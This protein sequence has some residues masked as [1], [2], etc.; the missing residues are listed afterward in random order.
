MKFSAV[1]IRNQQFSVSFRGY[2]KDEVKLFLEKLADEYEKLDNELESLKKENEKNIAELTGYRNTEKNLQ[3]T[4]LKAR[5]TSVKAIEAAKKQA[6]AIVR[7]AEIKSAQLIGS[8][9]QNADEMRSTVIKLR[10][11]KNLIVAKLKAFVQSQSRLL[12]FETAE[13][14]DEAAAAMPAAQPAEEIKPVPAADDIDIEDI[15]KK[16]D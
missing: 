6:A 9:R 8:A 4:L 16:L 3:S 15:L 10:E 2:D 5:D 1:N 7:E 13:S 12:D 11:E 14:A